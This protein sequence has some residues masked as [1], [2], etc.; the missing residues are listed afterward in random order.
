MPGG[1][2]FLENYL[3]ERKRRRNMQVDV[4]T[5]YAGMKP[6]LHLKSDESGSHLRREWWN[7]SHGASTRQT[8]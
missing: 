2:A 5:A 1:R 3:H 7:W 4:L 8:R 6:Q